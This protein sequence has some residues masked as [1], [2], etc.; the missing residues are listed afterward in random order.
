MKINT[1]IISNLTEEEKEL[2]DILK[3]VTN[4][5]V[6]YVTCRVAG[7][8]VR[9]RLL[10]KESDDIDIMVDKISGSDF[11]KLVTQYLNIKDPHVIKAN[12]DASK[13]METAGATIPLPSGKTI[14]VDFAMARKEVYHDNSRIPDIKPATP[15]EDAMRRDITI[16]AC[17]F[18]INTSQIEDFTGKGIR[19]LITNTIRTPLDPLITFKE[20]PLRLFR[21]IRFS[22]KYNWDIDTD[23]Y[24]AI[25]N[26]ELKEDIKRKISKERIKDEIVKMIK[27]PNPIVAINLLKQTGL[28]EDII[29]E[30]IKGSKFESK[31]SKLDMNQN[32]PNHELNLW[33]HTVQV[34]KNI[35]NQYPNSDDEKRV[36]MIL[37]AIMHD[38]GKLYSEVQTSKEG[39]TQ[40]IGHEAES[41]LL[42][43]II[44]K[45]LKFENSMIEQVSKIT[46][47]HMIPHTLLNSNPT[48]L[49]RFIRNM[50][51]K[52][53]SW[54]DV[55]NHAI[56]DAYSKSEIP[57]QN[58]ISDYNQLKQKLEEA[59]Q[60]M[61]VE[62]KKI[63][64]VLNGFEIMQLLNIKPGPIMSTINEY[65]KELQDENPN[66]TKEEASEKIKE[67]F[68]KQD[69]NIN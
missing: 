41:S 60:S 22:A 53:I 46:E 57:D 65:L 18:N 26:P 19:D 17:F 20:D 32:N 12:P 2:F 7:G 13:H 9:D 8:W 50:A 48:T 39:R 58:T 61:K 30:A 6:P 28:F 15:E 47:S 14:D 43:Q 49:R 55:L 4:K 34:V 68:L 21:C 23:T 11:A 62:K 24:N 52:S 29:S 25:L 69:Q 51:E 54:I 31:L 10:G 56:S 38:L 67:K 45:Y 36:I 66:I 44:L 37:S 63:I 40:Y 33:N 59:Y 35:I 42:S 1:N 64:P 5:Y 16:N 27:G 3:K